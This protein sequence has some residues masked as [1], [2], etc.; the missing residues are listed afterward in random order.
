MVASYPASHSWEEA[1]TDVAVLIH[2]QLALRDILIEGTLPGMGTLGKSTGI[3]CVVGAAF[4]QILFPSCTVQ[5][6]ARMT[7]SLQRCA[8]IGTFNCSS[9][10]RLM[11]TGTIWH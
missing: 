9:I 1:A 7:V 2:V 3:V 4:A 5:R 8:A 11:T 10:N 6:N